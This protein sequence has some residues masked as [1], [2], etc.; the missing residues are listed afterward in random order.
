MIIARERNQKV[1]NEEEHAVICSETDDNDAERG[2]EPSSYA[3]CVRSPRT[4][5]PT[6]ETIM[7]PSV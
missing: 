5:V 4:P 3:K 2:S 1:L 7:F 6:I